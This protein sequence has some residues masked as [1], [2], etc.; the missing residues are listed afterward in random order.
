MTWRINF[1]KESPNLMKKFMEFVTATKENSVEE[2]IRNLV[3]VRIA[4]L[5][6]CTHRLDMHIKHAKIQGERELHL[7][8]VASWREPTLSPRA[9]S[10]RMGGNRDETAGSP[11]DVYERVDPR[12]CRVQV[13]TGLGRCHARP[14]QSRPEVNNAAHRIDWCAFQLEFSYSRSEL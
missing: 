4:Q 13:S 11:D 6:N 1:A 14:R 2:S 7:Y 12:K 3:K 5:R 8:D 9:R 10:S